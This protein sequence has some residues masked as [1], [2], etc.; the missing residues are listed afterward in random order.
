MLV[1]YDFRQEPS[2]ST[3]TTI[4]QREKSPEPAPP[5]QKSECCFFCFGL[6][7]WKKTTMSF[8]MKPWHCSVDVV[9]ERGGGEQGRR[10]HHASEQF[11]AKKRLIAWWP[12]TDWHGYLR[13]GT[14]TLSKG[15]PFH[16]PVLEIMTQSSLFQCLERCI[17][18][19]F[20]LLASVSRQSWV[21]EWVSE[22]AS[23]VS[24]KK[25]RTS[26]SRH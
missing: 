5:P 23:S 20:L 7:A 22:E 16:C 12:W 19:H 17:S 18:A 10:T 8:W 3:C 1:E 25:I 21:S 24:H 15:K 26:V 13:Q 9:V 2:A 14:C 11:A 6:F 4:D